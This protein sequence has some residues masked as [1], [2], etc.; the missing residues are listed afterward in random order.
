MKDE[1]L[2]TTAGRHPEDNHG[3][4]NPPVYHVSTVL[5]PTL[6][7]AEGALSAKVSYGRHGT[8]GTFA[9]EEA[10]SALE[11]AEVTRILPSGLAACTEAILAC[12]SAGDHVLVTDSV[13]EPTRNFCSRFLSRFGVETSYY[14]PLVGAGIAALI[15][16]NT[17][18]VFTEAPGSRTF[19]MQDIGAIA[20][21][22]HAAGDIFVLMDNTWATPLYFKPLAHGVDL[23]IQAAT[24]YVVGHSDAMLGTISANKRCAERLTQ[25]HRLLG[26]SA[27]PDDVYLALR[28]LRTMATRLKQHG[29]TGLTLAR[30]LKARPEVDR[31]L[32]PALPGDPGHEIWQR[33]FA[34]ASGLFG[35]VMKP[36]SKTALAAMIDPME[37]FKIGYSWGGFE[38]LITAGDPSRARTATK[39]PGPG[40]LVRIHAG[41]EHPDDLLADLERAFARFNAA[42]G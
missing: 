41:L 31:V 26:M 21:A 27:G 19:E 9:L 42:S 22:A 11:G 23:S 1:T 33:D 8:P 38:S 28:G 6:A 13:Y 12:V 3:I 16:P 15:K 37:H 35:F 25:T 17:K 18:V 5:F 4:V 39:W 34:G 14:D 10:M 7:D 20:R 40:P 32:H 29:E 24:K 30:W 2:V 36:C